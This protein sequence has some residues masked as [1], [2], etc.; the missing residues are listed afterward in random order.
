M[1][2]KRLLGVGIGWILP[3]ALL[4][5]WYFAVRFRF[6]PESLLA[7]PADVLVDFFRLSVS[8]EIWRHAAISLTRLAEGFF[9]GAC[10]GVALG[11]LAGVSQFWDMFF[12]PI[13][14]VLAPIPPI[15]WIPFLII[16]FG[17]GEGSKVALVA[18]SS[19]VI[20][21][22]NTFQGMRSVDQRYVEL[23][24]S[25]RKPR[26]VLFARV[27]FPSA[28]PQI[29]TGLRIA[30]G[31]CWILLVAAELIASSGGLGWF[32]WDARSFSR[33]DDMIVGMI[34]LGVLGA[35]SDFAAL[36]MERRLLSWRVS[37]EGI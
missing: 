17:I 14:R 22:I 27:L 10:I 34:V 37:F 1:G 32:I 15:G 20:L 11:S 24:Q 16:V 33:P 5:F 3:L 23:S 25:L 36:R 12:S 6:V 13:V 31:S 35:T 19:F 28:L 30:L 4:L 26:R 8:G 2:H 21:Y 18:I 9:L 29:M 7:S